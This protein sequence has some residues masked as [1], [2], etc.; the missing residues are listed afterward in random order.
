[1]TASPSSTTATGLPLNGT[2]VKTS[3]C[4]KA[5]VLISSSSSRASRF[6]RSESAGR[7]RQEQLQIIEYR[8][9]IVIGPTLDGVRPCPRC[10][11]ENGRPGTTGATDAAVSV[12][13]DRAVRD[14]SR[15]QGHADPGSTR[16]LASS[17][18][19]AAWRQSVD[20]APSVPSAR[21]SR[22][23]AGATAVGFL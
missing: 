10:G 11:C 5:S 21:G 19:Q 22:D 12:R 15:G 18:H 6:P 8:T 13:G 16:A 17:D 1:D 4:W 7:P 14:R 9:I 20:R 23:L 2:A 3:T